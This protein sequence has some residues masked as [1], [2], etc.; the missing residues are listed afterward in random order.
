ML[1]RDYHS[2]DWDMAKILLEKSKKQL[3]KFDEP[4][5]AKQLKYIRDLERKHKVKFE[6]KTKY[7]ASAFI[8]R[9]AAIRK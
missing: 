6:G 1:N 2:I 4:P 3:K 7:E 9:Y 5:T 8:G